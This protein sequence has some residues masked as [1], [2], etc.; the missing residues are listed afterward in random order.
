MSSE[1]HQLPRWPVFTSQLWTSCNFG[2]RKGRKGEIRSPWEVWI[3]H[4]SCPLTQP[5][6]EKAK[7]QEKQDFK[8]A[9]VQVNAVTQHTGFTNKA[10]RDWEWEWKVLLEFPVHGG[11]VGLVWSESTGSS[12]RVP[13]HLNGQNPP[14]ESGG[15]PPPKPSHPPG[16]SRLTPPP[17][18]AVLR[19]TCWGAEWIYWGDWW[20]GWWQ[21]CSSAP[22]SIKKKKK[23]EENAGE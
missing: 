9:P 5:L 20:P 1:T 18:C 12:G 8:T 19:G 3:W 13:A 7:F 4:T 10:K 2:K 16:S 17:V 6:Q 21:R 22:V 11:T 23:V 14:A 15:V